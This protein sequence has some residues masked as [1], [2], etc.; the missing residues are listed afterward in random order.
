MSKLKDLFSS[1][2]QKDNKTKA[3]S[4]SNNNLKHITDKANKILNL[5]NDLKTFKD[6]KH[7]I[8]NK[9]FEKFFQKKNNEK[10][11]DNNTK[12]KIEEKGDIFNQLE[13]RTLFEKKMPFISG[14]KKI[15]RNSIQIPEKQYFM[16]NLFSEIISI[17]ENSE[18]LGF[19]IDN[20]YGLAYFYEKEWIFFLTEEI[21]TKNILLT[22]QK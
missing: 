11:N 22:Q 1:K 2:S 13:L 19:P 6:Y 20:K 15:N 17:M 8:K 4:L 18:L 3:Y 14:K 7:E 5:K 21:H 16:S 10:K 9:Y 12:N